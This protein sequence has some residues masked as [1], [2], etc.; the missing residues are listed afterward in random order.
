MGPRVVHCLWARQG[1]AGQRRL[2]LLSPSP[3][4]PRGKVACF[5]HHCLDKGV[6]KKNTEEEIWRA[7]VPAP[8]RGC[9]SSR[10]LARGWRHG[11][12]VWLPA[13]APRA[14][15]WAPFS[16]F[17]HKAVCSTQNKTKLLSLLRLRV[18]TLGHLAS[19]HP[20]AVEFPTEIRRSAGNAPRGAREIWGDHS[21]GGDWLPLFTSQPGRGAE[22]WLPRSRLGG[23]PQGLNKFRWNGL[24]GEQ[25]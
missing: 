17:F 10:S 19:L 3:G 9:P 20:L 4:S 18:N 8:G 16:P 12:S 2:F 6:L 21:S 7:L 11:P 24:S 15:I 13:R 5:L 14:R 22:S 1:E 23:K 25:N